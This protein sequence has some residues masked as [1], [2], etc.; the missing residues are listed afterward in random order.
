MQQLT[1]PLID[2][3]VGSRPW[4]GDW[5]SAAQQSDGA[6]SVQA[7]VGAATARR[8]A[9]TVNSDAHR[10]IKDSYSTIH[11]TAIFHI[12]WFTAAHAPLRSRAAR[13]V[14]DRGDAE[15]AIDRLNN[16]VWNVDQSGS[17]RTAARRPT[18]YG[19][20]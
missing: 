4:H 8:L 12:I 18:A 6:L 19:A 16:D 14:T 17:A 9:Q 1:A 3:P 11:T 20:H 13:Q 5:E 15:D 7:S 2:V 10:R